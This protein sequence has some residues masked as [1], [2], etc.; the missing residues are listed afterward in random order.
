MHAT[1]IRLWLSSRALGSNFWLSTGIWSSSLI[2]FLFTLPLCRYLNIPLD[3]IALTEALP[4]LVCT[5]GFEKPLRLAKAVLAHPQALKPQE[6]GRMKPAGEIV[7]DA[8]DRVGNVIL[9]DYALEIA[10]LLVGVNSG[11]GGLKEF[12]SVAAVALGMDCLMICT[13]Y[14]A[15]LTV[16]VEVSVLFRARPLLPPSPQSVCWSWGLTRIRHVTNLT[17]ASASPGG[18]CALSP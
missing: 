8:L 9:R 15:V 13:F 17:T 1:F 11:V 7:L 6:D 10:V 4:F 5:V 14:T 12:C 18:G 2:S 16:M 3:P